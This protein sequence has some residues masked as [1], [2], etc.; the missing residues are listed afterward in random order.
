MKLKAL[1]GGTSEILK[2]T[3]DGF[4]DHKVTKLSG[5]LAY[6]TLF[7]I[8][9]LLIIVIAVCGFFFGRAATE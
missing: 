6:S 9:P 5:S 8:G 3:F 4:L 7:S 2:N 1:P